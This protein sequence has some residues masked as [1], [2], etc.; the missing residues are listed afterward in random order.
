[1]DPERTGD[2]PVVTKDT[3]KALDHDVCNDTGFSDRVF[4]R[5][6][7]W[8]HNLMSS[9]VAA[10]Y[11]QAEGDIIKQASFIRGAEYIL[12]ALERTTESNYLAA[13]WGED[14]E[15]RLPISE[16]SPEIV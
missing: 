9:V 13:L 6:N 1:M 7:K 8:N 5:H 2:L 4:Q 10:A 14:Q 16:D 3:L 12:A 15:V 11:K